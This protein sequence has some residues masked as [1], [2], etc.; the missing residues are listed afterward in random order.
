MKTETENYAIIKIR[1]WYG[2]NDTLSVYA[3]D[4][5]SSYSDDLE[6]Y[7]QMTLTEARDVVESEE[8]DTYYLAHNEAG[9]AELLIVPESTI[10]EIIDIHNDGSCVDW[11]DYTGDVDDASAASQYILQ[12]TVNIARA[13]EVNAL[14]CTNKQTTNI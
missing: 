5:A 7:D 3:E 14:T 4:E 10:L 12:Q 1:S 2:T 6:D 11:S 8:S 9:R 13:G